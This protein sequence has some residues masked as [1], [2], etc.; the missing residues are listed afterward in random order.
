MK[1]VK[2]IFYKKLEF[3]FKFLDLF[4]TKRKLSNARESKVPQSEG[5]HLFNALPPNSFYFSK[6]MTSLKTFQKETSTAKVAPDK[7][8]PASKSCNGTNG[9]INL[10]I[11]CSLF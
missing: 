7:N 2:K 1:F 8:G 3:C 5:Q 4:G 10:N 9:L 6:K 11:A